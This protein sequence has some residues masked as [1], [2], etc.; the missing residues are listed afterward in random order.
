MCPF[1]NDPNKPCRVLEQPDGKLVASGYSSIS[2]VVQPVLIRID[3]KGV[4]DAV[5]NGERERV[6][7]RKSARQLIQRGLD[8]NNLQLW[9]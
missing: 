9:D 5:K 3:G 1:C 8:E 7:L 2:G 6:Q 4:L